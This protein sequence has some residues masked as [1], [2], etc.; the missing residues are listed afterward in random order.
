MSIVSRRIRSRD[1]TIEAWQAVLH[2]VRTARDP[3]DA[4]PAVCIGGAPAAASNSAAEDSQRLPGTSV[5]T[6]HDT[7]GA[8]DVDW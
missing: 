4:G 2:G 6:L 5:P 8:S 7:T 1:A 3:S